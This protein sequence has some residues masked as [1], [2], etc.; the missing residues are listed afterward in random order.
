MPPKVPPFMNKV[1]TIGNEQLDKFDFDSVSALVE[2]HVATQIGGI[3][4]NGAGCISPP[5]TTYDPATKVLT[6]GAF[7]YYLSVADVTDD[8]GVTYKGWHG[9]VAVV[10]PSDSYQ[11][12]TISLA[13]AAAIALLDVNPAPGAFPYIYVRPVPID[14]DLAGRRQ[15]VG[16]ASTAVT[17]KTRTRLSH[18]FKLSMLLPNDNTNLGWA[19]VAQVAAWS[20]PGPGDA[21]HPG[22]PIIYPISCWDYVDDQTNTGT[23]V[24]DPWYLETPSASPILAKFLGISLDG[25]TDSIANVFTPSA[26]KSKDL[27]LIQILSIMRHR[28]AHMLDFANSTHWYA[29]ALAPQNTAPPTPTD[30][31]SAGGGVLALS[32]LVNELRQSPMSVAGYATSDG[33]GTYTVSGNLPSGFTA[34]CFMAGGGNAG[35]LALLIYYDAAKYSFDAIDV[36]VYDPGSIYTAMG[37]SVTGFLDVNIAGVHHTSID[38]RLWDAAKALTQNCGIMFTAHYRRGP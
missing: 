16:G 5:A 15:F 25:D 38:I 37:V 1:R 33:A 22:S 8:D 32:D 6:I 21:T 3:L 30:L 26:S 24:I 14:T 11:Q 28:M 36:T 31:Q 13:A 35:M 18:E 10:D 4:G 34:Q 9:G 12:T 17:V 27:S 23:T 29:N 7:Q 20:N 2:Q 19:P